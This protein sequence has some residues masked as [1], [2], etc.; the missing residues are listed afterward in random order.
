[1]SDGMGT[2]FS[3][4]LVLEENEPGNDYG[5]TAKTSADI[6][7]IMKKFMGINRYIKMPVLPYDG[8]HH[9]D[10]H[11]KLLDEETLLVGEYPAGVADGPQIEANLQ[12]VLSNYMSPFGTPYKV[13]R[14][15]MPPGSNGNYPDHQ[16]WWDAGEYRTYTNAVFV[17]KTVLLP[18][19]EEQ[20]DTTALRIWREALPGYNVVGINAN[21]PIQASGAIHCITHSVGVHDPLL[22]THQPLRDQPYI[23]NATYTVA[24]D[25]K[26]RSGINSVTLYY[27]TDTT[28]P[29]SSTPMYIGFVG[30]TWFA[31]IPHQG[32][33][34]TIYYYVHA[35]AVSGKT[36]NR[37]IVAPDGY[38]KFRVSEDI[39]GTNNPNAA[40]NQMLDVFPN[41]ARA[42]TCVPINVQMPTDGYL[43]I[44]DVWGR[45]LQT[46]HNGTFDAGK[47]QFFFDASVFSA[48]VYFIQWQTPQGIQ[49]QRVVVR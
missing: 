43:G 11:I 25:V 19:Y 33:N 6:D 3:S 34:V 17:N 45:C 31:D 48:G 1:M 44:Y 27:R 9:I 32:N 16:P 7:T 38:W 4:E 37:P 14:V 18:V 47:Q 41:P 22:I 42:I 13:V 29:Y 12:Y 21:A 40:N 23:P 49:Y 8:I 28:Q 5:V 26:H 30:D 24:A 46:L 36:Q 35:E 2:A 39:S 10:M 20:Y 15:T